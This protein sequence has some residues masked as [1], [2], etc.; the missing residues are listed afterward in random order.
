MLPDNVEIMLKLS[1]V[2]FQES[3]T[4]PDIEQSQELLD[5]VIAINSNNADA[6]LL[7]GKILHKLN[8]FPEA[9]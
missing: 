2:L 9:I 5:K 3:G 1:G 7:K 4:E 8:Q 6:Y